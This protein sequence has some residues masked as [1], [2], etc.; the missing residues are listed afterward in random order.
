MK[1]MN[2]FFIDFFIHF[3]CCE[4]MADRC[5]LRKETMSGSAC[6]E[7]VAVTL[8][9]NMGRGC[10]HDLEGASQT[11]ASQIVDPSQD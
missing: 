11:D 4:D 7:R 10:R 6:K 8:I 5:R 3:L 1:C 9:P 2:E